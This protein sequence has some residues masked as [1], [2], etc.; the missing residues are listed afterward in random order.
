MKRLVLIMIIPA[1]ICGVIVFVSSCKDKVDYEG[2]V[3]QM[4]FDS[5]PKEM[6]V[7]DEVTLK[8]LVLPVDADV[9]ITWVT[10]PTNDTKVEIENDGSEQEERSKDVFWLAHKIKVIAK[11]TGTANIEFTYISK[12][13]DGNNE[14]SNKHNCSIKIV[15]KAEE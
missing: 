7:G 6:T 3:E 2:L 15:E 5:Y 14:I 10:I 11:S 13:K 12:S 1:L 8:F 4:F 9:T